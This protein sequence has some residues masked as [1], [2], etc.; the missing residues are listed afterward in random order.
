MK[1]LFVTTGATV[2]FDPLVELFT[3]P[4]ILNYLSKEL[5]ITN[6]TIQHGVEA[7]TELIS[8][9]K[10]ISE[11]ELSNE[12][13][14][15]LVP[16]INDI[17]TEI[18]KHDLI[19]SHGG[20]EILYLFKIL[21]NTTDTLANLGTGSILDALRLKKPLIVVVNPTL[22]NNHQLDIATALEDQNCLISCSEPTK[23]RLLDG[24]KRLPTFHFEPLPTPKPGALSQIIYSEAG[25][26]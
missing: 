8:R 21:Y 20:I 9:L 14:I 17:N 26:I 13:S 4:E 7:S 23:S 3:D 6:I 18:Q 5:Q 11:K 10:T 2:P 16:F 22:L 12:I 25:L 24:L 19:I 1:S 15:E